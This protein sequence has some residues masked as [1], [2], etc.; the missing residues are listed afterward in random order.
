MSDQPNSGDLP[1]VS[2]ELP[3][4]RFR[5]DGNRIVEALGDIASGFLK[6]RIW[7]QLA[8]EDFIERYRRAYFGVLWAIFGFILFSFAIIF[9][10]SA[11]T[12]GNVTS[13]A[14]YI[15]FGFLFYQLLTSMVIDASLLFVGARAWIKST[16]MPYSLYVFKGITRA[17]TL[18]GFNVIG[19]SI[20]L[21]F[22]N[23]QPTL[24]AL[25]VLP[26]LLAILVN[27]VWVYLF[28]GT[29]LARLRDVQHL[30]AFIVRMGIFFTPVM[31]R[32]GDDPFRSMIALFN[33]LTHF[34]DICRIPLVEGHP[35]VQ[36][37]IIVGC[38]TVVGWILA[39]AVFIAFRRRII[40]W[41]T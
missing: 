19:A 41:I 4:S 3:G 21:F 23:Y 36:S 8:W 2:L 18:F 30:L 10:V 28:L 39:L 24:G 33:P 16:R 9:F 26:G 14:L 20:M 17:M 40:F 32:P 35:P 38:L 12:D 37:W 6:F 27:A 25:W 22:F 1:S 11:V 29:I 13:G 5:S 7:R 34:I 15:L 31:W